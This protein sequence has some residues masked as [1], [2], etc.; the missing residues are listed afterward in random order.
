[1]NYK[2]LCVKTLACLL[3]L[4]PQY[5]LA[6][7]RYTYTSSPV[8]DIIANDNMR[9]DEFKPIS[10]ND[11]LT[12]V[13]N[14]PTLLVQVIE[15]QSGVNPIGYFENAST[16]ISFGAYSLTDTELEGIVF[17]NLFV[18]EYDANGLPTAWSFNLVNFPYGNGEVPEY[19]RGLQLLSDGDANGAYNEIFSYINVPTDEYYI[20]AIARG[21]GK[22]TL[23]QISSTVPEVETYA[24]MMAGLGLIGFISRRK[25]IKYQLPTHCSNTVN[26]G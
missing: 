10:N 3:F 12:I 18:N 14:S 11:F 6:A 5:V 4:L 8:T 21:T 9:G 22:W 20:N 19:F 16:Q 2:T 7:Y 23:E 15:Y 13:I 24:M 17:R 25:K 26:A 1:M